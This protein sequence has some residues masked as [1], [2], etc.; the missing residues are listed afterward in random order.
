[1]VNFQQ[2]DFKVSLKQIKS[3]CRQ[4]GSKLIV[5]VCLRIQSKLHTEW[6]NLDMVASSY[7]PIYSWAKIK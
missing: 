4:Y 2:I 7:S 1:M 6:E 3:T 5:D